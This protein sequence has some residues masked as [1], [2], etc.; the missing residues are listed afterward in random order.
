M[1][2]HLFK[3]EIE[4]YATNFFH[5]NLWK[6]AATHDLDDAMQEAWFVFRKCD[7]TYPDTEPAHFM[8]LFKTALNNRTMN[9]AKTATRVRSS[10]FL[11]HQAD[12]E[13]IMEVDAQ[14]GETDNSG[15]LSRL[16]TQAP[17][18]V[19]Q[20]L[21]LF[22]SAP[23]EILEAAMDAWQGSGKRGAGGNEHVCKLLGLPD[24]SKPLDAVQEY[25]SN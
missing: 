13:L 9:L 17:A 24:G 2:T 11:S 7:A 5:K 1:S 4:G 8:A 19:K 10:I 3:G 16:I 18:E 22:L 14:I 25:F 15:Y 6:I 20:V 23:S 12:S 21:S